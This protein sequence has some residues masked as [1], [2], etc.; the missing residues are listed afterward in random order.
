VEIALTGIGS[1]VAYNR[2]VI[3]PQ[4]RA[5]RKIQTAAV[6]RGIVGVGVGDSLPSA[7]P[8]PQQKPTGGNRKISLELPPI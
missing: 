3:A 1:Y 5:Q 7:Q 2:L 6:A 8:L 4:Q